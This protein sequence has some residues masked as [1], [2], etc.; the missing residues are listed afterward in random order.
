MPVRIHWA[1]DIEA[2][3]GDDM[4]YLFG[5]S[6]VAPEMRSYHDVAHV[7]L[8]TRGGVVPLGDASRCR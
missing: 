4:S 3:Q 7:I 1:S 5:A 2:S 8:D 6:K